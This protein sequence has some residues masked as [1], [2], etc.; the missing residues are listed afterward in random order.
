MAST[1]SLI[2][3]YD[4]IIKEQIGI[5]VTTI[6]TNPCSTVTNISENEHQASEENNIINEDFKRIYIL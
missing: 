6:G 5:V 3:P 4:N 2:I 1:H